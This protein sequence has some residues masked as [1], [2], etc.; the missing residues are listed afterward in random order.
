VL[1][2][3]S[4]LEII[5]V[6]VRMDWS[7]VP[8]CADP[9]Q[10][11]ADRVGKSF[12][13]PWSDEQTSLVAERSHC[14]IVVERSLQENVVPPRRVEARHVD[15]IVRARNATPVGNRGTVKCVD[16]AEFGEPVAPDH[17][18]VRDWE[19]PIALFA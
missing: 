7:T 14:L 9:E 11:L 19:L 13:R 17:P 10:L 12:V 1:P 5:P 16:A 2:K 6:E 18:H 8:A 4:E 15:A 3:P